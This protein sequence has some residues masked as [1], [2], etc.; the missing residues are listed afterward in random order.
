MCVGVCVH[1]VC[2]CGVYVCMCVCAANVCICR[3]MWCVYMCA[4]ELGRETKLLNAL[5]C[6]YLHT[7]VCMR[8]H[9]CVGCACVYMYIVVLNITK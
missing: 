7:T 8:M 9:A 1:Y 4:K 5:K 3:A 6:V 2:M